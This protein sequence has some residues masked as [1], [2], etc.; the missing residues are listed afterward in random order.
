M[1]DLTKHR[2]CR[3]AALDRRDEASSVA[4]VFQT[5][6]ERDLRPGLAPPIAPLRRATFRQ[7]LL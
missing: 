2:L 1:E 3:R 6:Y 4:P 7:A 5:K